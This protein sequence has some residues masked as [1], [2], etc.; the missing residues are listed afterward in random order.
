MNEWLKTDPNIGPEDDVSPYNVPVAVRARTDDRAGLVIVEFRYIDGDE[1]RVEQ[2]VDEHLS[3]MMG[4]H[5]A[6]VLALH[7]DRDLFLEAAAQD[8]L[9]SLRCLGE[10]RVKNGEIS[11]QPYVTAAFRERQQDLL[12]QR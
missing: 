6:R 1:P 10:V 12:M 4:R 5:S 9:L 2:V 8:N 7:F 11:N 3:I